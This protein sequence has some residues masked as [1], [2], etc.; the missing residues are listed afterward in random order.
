[1]D[2]FVWFFVNKQTNDN[3]LLYDE[4]TLIKLRKIAWASVSPFRFKLQCMS[5]LYICWSGSIYTYIYIDI[6][7]ER[8]LPF[9]C[10]QQKT[11]ISNF[12]LLAAN[13]KR[14]REVCFP[15][16]ENYKWQLTI[17]VTANVPIYGYVYLFSCIRIFW[18]LFLPNGKDPF[19][20][21]YCTVQCRVQCGC[22][23]FLSTGVLFVFQPGCT[24]SSPLLIKI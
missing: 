1:M 21:D 3:F 20:D 9:V 15:Y 5:I 13:G 12:C 10:C 14:K 2:N 23:M 7:T 4:Q 24:Y 19:P 16:L 8:Q 6:H 18:F 22:R 11:E 17:A